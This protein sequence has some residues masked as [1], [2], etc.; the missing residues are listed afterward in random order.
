MGTQ[1]MQACAAMQAL[2]GF[3]D[4][5]PNHGVLEYLVRFVVILHASAVAT[6]L[7]PITED[8]RSYDPVEANSKIAALKAELQ[9]K[10]ELV[11][12]LKE[13]LKRSEE[14]YDELSKKHKAV[15]RKFLTA[16]PQMVGFHQISD[17]RLTSK[18]RILRDSICNFGLDSFRDCQIKWPER[19][20]ADHNLPV[21][22]F[23]RSWKTITPS[24]ME[25]YT[26]HILDRK[27]F[28]KFVWA[29]RDSGLPEAWRNIKGMS[30]F[31][32]LASS[33]T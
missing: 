16:K 13:D 4:S 6:K 27:I 23:I 20:M 11:T 18:V 1:W 19:Y 31:S 26:W 30:L 5:K 3:Q 25:M 9:E 28:G 32:E 21:L 14:K 29:G 12:Q 33:T 8:P 15:G 17:A 2:I 24:D 22:G 7:I 10:T